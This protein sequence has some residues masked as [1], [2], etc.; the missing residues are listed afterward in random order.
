MDVF[1]PVPNHRS[2]QRGAVI[3]MAGA[4]LLMFMAFA[5]IGVDVARLAFTANETQTVADIAAL[6]AIQ[7]RANEVAN[8]VADAQAVVQENQVDGQPADVGGGGVVNSVIPGTWDFDAQTFVPTGDWY[9]P[10]TNAA[11][12]NAEATVD[13]MVAGVINDSQSSVARSAIAAMGGACS[14]ELVMPLALGPCW[15]DEF[16][17]SNDCSDIPRFFQ[18]PATGNTCFTSLSQDPA[19]APNAAR[20]LPTSCCNNGGN[21]GLGQTPALVN[22]GDEINVINGQ[23]NVLM[24]IIQ[25]CFNQG[26]TEWTIPL[27]ECGQCNQQTEVTGFAKIVITNVIDTGNPAGRG[28]YLD[29]ICKLDPE[30]S[31]GC[32][33]AGL[34]GLALVQ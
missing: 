6:A 15:F 18:V 19:S 16:E 8:P 14:G 24:Q 2:R 30:V 3:A 10:D 21:C 26:L 13:N 20:Y 1:P 9:D 22:I 17:D 12:A 28:I 27:V 33:S 4:M 25:S 11:Q 7:G 5:V 23:V 32:A 34:T 31:P 29:S